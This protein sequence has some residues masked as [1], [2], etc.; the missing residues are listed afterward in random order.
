MRGGGPEYGDPFPAPVDCNRTASSE[1]VPVKRW[2][3]WEWSFDADASKTQLWIDGQ[4]MTQVDLSPATPGSCKTVQGPKRF[5]KM[6]IGW[7]VYTTP[8]ELAQE[9][10]IDD[11]VVGAERVGCPA[12]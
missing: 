5:N 11:I 3:C 2:L 6:V 9:V 8:S 1:P 12:P 4:P 7:D 10:W